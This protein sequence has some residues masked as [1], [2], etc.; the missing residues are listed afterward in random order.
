MLPLLPLLLATAVLA[1]PEDDAW[2]PLVMVDGS[3]H[4]STLLS[5]DAVGDGE[6]SGDHLDLVGEQCG[7]TPT[8][9]WVTGSDLLYLRIRLAGS[10]IDDDALLAGAWGA[11]IDLD[12]TTSRDD[13]LLILD[14]TSGLLQLWINSMPAMGWQDTAEDLAISWKAPFDNDQARITEAGTSVG[15]GSDH[16]LDLAVPS[17][18]FRDALALQPDDRIGL[19]VATGAGGQARLASDLAGCDASSLDC[20][21]LDARIE[22]V[23][24]SDD[25]DG[26]GLAD[27]DEVSLGTNPVDAD[28][29][30]DGMLDGAEVDAG[31]DPLVCDSD[32]DGLIDG[33][34]AGITEPHTD[35]DAFTEC[36]LPDTDPDTTTDPATADTDGDGWLDG[37]E[38]TNSNGAIDT[39]ELDPNDP[40]DATDSD[41]DDIP[42]VL[43]EYCGGDDSDDRDGDGITDETEGLLQSDDDGDPD[44]CDTDS[45]ADGW[46]DEHEGDSDS[47]G[48]G[49]PDYIDTDSD[50][51]GILDAWEA[52]GDAD[53]DGL[54]LRV[55]PW[56]QD[57][58]CGD[59]DGDGW[60][61]GKEAACGTD[62]SD[63]GSYPASL[64]DCFGPDTDSPQ[65]EPGIPSYSGGHFG[66]G[67]H[68][69][70]AAASIALWLLGLALLAARRPG[71]GAAGLLLALG[72]GAAPARAQDLDVQLYRPT[73][74]QGVFIGLEDA[75]GT[76]EGLG[77]T[78]A[79]TYAQAPLVYHY[80]SSDRA[81]EPVVS[82]LGSLDL[83]PWWRIGPLRLGLHVPLPLV[84][85]G[86]GVS[87]PHWIG[88]LAIDAK[89]LLLDRLEHPI[90]LAVHARGTA[91]TGNTEAWVGSGVPTASADLDL[92]IGKRTVAVANLGAATGNGTLLDDLV[93]GPRLHWGLGLQTPLT[94]PITMVIEL[95]G[96]H[97]LE[98]LDERGAHPLEALLG[99][100]SRPVGPWVGSL[101]LGTGLGKGLGAPA[102]RLVTGLSYVP[103]APDAPPGLFVD[104]DRDGLV[105]EHDAC[106][107]QP[108]DYDGRTD[109]DGCPDAGMAPVRISLHGPD[110]QHLPGGSLSLLDGDRATDSWRLQEGQLVRSL[111]A[112]QQRV[113]VSAPGHHPLR[114][115]LVLTEAKAH[116][117]TCQPP[118]RV[119]GSRAR[120]ASSAGGDPDGD[121]IFGDR[122]R[123]PDQP[124][125]P[126]DTDDEDGCPDGYLTPT[127][128]VLTDRAG[129]GLPA[130]QLLLVSGPVTGA[131]DAPGGLFQRALVPGSYLLVAQAEGYSP[132]E[133]DLTIPEANDQLVTLELEPATALA[134]VL[135]EVRSTDGDPLPARAWA[136]G[137]LELL[138]DT[139]DRGEL[140]LA[141]PAGSYDLHV[142]AAG[143]RSHR[144][145]LELE[146]DATTPVVIELQPLPEAQ[147]QPSGLPIL[148][149]RLI[150]VPSTNLGPD[151][152]L[153]LR[154][155]ADSLRAHPEIVLVTLAGWVPPSADKG[156]A[157]R[158][159]TALAAATQAWLVEHEGIEAE[160][161]LAVGLGSLEP[162]EGE[163]R[164]LRGVEVRP[165]VAFERSG[166]AMAQN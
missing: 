98:S 141:L 45:D 85:N 107:D 160:R 42:D 71:S 102:L 24:V 59:F 158:A 53:C 12:G 4:H 82:N 124:E 154:A 23:P 7:D 150:P 34:E 28:T 132:L 83:M 30:D 51:D 104:G 155:L 49:T 146:P 111:P 135:L 73:T 57:G 121:T 75:R 69:S 136:R 63:A 13:A 31:S 115:E 112:G 20:S 164:P 87:G 110:G 21:T 105:D 60:I 22:S 138:R 139:D 133:L 35:T 88:D 11:L 55:D 128:F 5:W 162:R 14:G 118:E 74:D 126:N 152:E 123:C 99:I 90:G 10:P 84:A 130:G 143:Y 15:G 117:V 47:D 2:E 89:W 39:W 131:W 156:K 33:L 145:S 3:C 159:S 122:D 58:P 61:N 64:E 151:Q 96:A 108:E 157:V 17:A 95:H 66:G 94:D 113:E 161:L 38:D 86:S 65:I 54:E 148:H 101:G 6:E 68:S 19:F 29:D 70:G 109:R 142:S 16:F 129:A 32:R 100:R 103:R 52:S 127:R 50:D 91:P 80:K 92:A 18:D 166:G 72:L 93:L 78:L 116:T 149:P 67:C 120:A 134:S 119:A 46:S 144:D 62:P 40:D 8:A 25:V 56:H 1:W 9:Y 125:D 79:F 41:G 140:A 77:G 114:F 165:A 26:D 106:P 97:L 76:A 147:A 163:D 137:S 44:F 153:A 36:W 27:D 43:E 81:T 37:E 48:D